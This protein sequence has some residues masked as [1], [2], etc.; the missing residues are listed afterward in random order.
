MKKSVREK[1]K[2]E[3]VKMRELDKNNMIMS[4]KDE[5]ETMK[6]IKE[7]GNEDKQSKK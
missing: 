4:L 7:K 6:Q 2:F 5:A 1:N 3:E